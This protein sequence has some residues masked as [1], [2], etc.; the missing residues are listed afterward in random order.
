MFVAWKNNWDKTERETFAIGYAK[1]EVLPDFDPGFL[2]ALAERDSPGFYRGAKQFVS[3]FEPTERVIV[4]RG[5]QDVVDCLAPRLGLEKGYGEE[6]D[7]STKVLELMHQGNFKRAIIV[8]DLPLDMQIAEDLKTK[9][10][11]ALAIQIA[12]SLDDYIPG[13][14]VMIL[15]DSFRA[16]QGYD[17]SQFNLEH[18]VLELSMN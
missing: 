7:K 16:F 18:S 9:G 6:M 17:L 14:A 15:R 3:I 12:G 13:A 5:F 1:R 10:Y 4:S 2:R 8:G 11:E